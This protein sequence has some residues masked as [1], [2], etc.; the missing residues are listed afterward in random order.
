MEAG[1]VS[2]AADRML[3]TQPAVSK[4]ISAFEASV[5]VPVFKREGGRLVPTPEA[6]Q[7]Y[8]EVD[9]V[10]SGISELDRFAHSLADRT[11]GHVSIGVLP[12]L[13]IGAV[14]EFVSAFL[15]ERPDVQISLQT[16][17]SMQSIEQLLLRKIDVGIAVNP[18]YTPEVDLR[19]LVDAKGVCILPYGHPLAE[20]DIVQASDLHQQDFISL[21]NLDGS[22]QRVEASF[23]NDRAKPRV[24]IETP[25]TATACACVA[26]G[27]GISIVDP[28][29]ADAFS[30]R[31][32]IRKYEP[33]VFFSIFS[34]KLSNTTSVTQLAHLF[35]DELHDHFPKQYGQLIERLHIR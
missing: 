16:R 29:V 31:L 3:I 27:M 15:T 20:K 10:F 34:C 12:A 4:L 33:D 28:F 24:R 30:H 18:P 11:S 32:Q 25:V 7:L 9:R 17:T 19:H 22:L 26:A 23:L 2:K 8:A 35:Q 14:Q 6:R 13:S 5:P 1:T 21:T